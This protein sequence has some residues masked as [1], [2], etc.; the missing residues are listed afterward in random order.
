[1]EDPQPAMPTSPVLN[2]TWSEQQNDEG[3]A[4]NMR[5]ETMGEL[6]EGVVAVEIPM[7]VSFPVVDAENVERLHALYG[8][9][10][11]SLGVPSAATGNLVGAEYWYAL[12]A[13]G[14]AFRLDSFLYVLQDWDHKESM[15]KV[16]YCIPIIKCTYL[17]LL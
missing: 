6:L 5:V 14:T 3:V 15:L 7:T 9:D 17:R 2:N 13:V 16:S 1:M 8:V 10:M 12:C 4:T 11:S